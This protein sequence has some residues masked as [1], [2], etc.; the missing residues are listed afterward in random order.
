MTNASSVVFGFLVASMVAPGWC[1]PVAAQSVT[2]EIVGEW[3]GQLNDPSGGL[4]A[5][6]EFE[7]TSFRSDTIHGP[8]SLQ[9]AG[10]E[11]PVEPDRWVSRPS[12]QERYDDLHILFTGSENGGVEGT[13]TPYRDSGCGCAMATTLIGT[14]NGD[15]ISGTYVAHHRGSGLNETGTW[16]VERK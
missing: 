8:I 5:A 7:L 2:R 10:R 4:V 11:D 6:I 1:E 3:V 16:W 13:L 14:V 12:Y 15:R 9:E